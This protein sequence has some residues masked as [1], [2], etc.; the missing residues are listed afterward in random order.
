MKITAIIENTSAC[1]IPTEHGLSLYIETSEQK[2][3]FDMGQTEL[4]E[5][6]AEALGIDLSEVD[7]AVLSHGH[8]DHG[9]GLKRFLEINQKAP[10]YISRHAFGRHYN[11]TEKY[12]GLDTAL[13]NNSMLVFTDEETE[14]SKKLKLYSCN[15]KPKKYDL[16]SFGLNMLQNNAFMP[17]DFKH[18]QYLLVE[19]KG[20]NVL[21]SGCSHK[22]VLDI[23]Q[24]FKPDVFVGGFHFNS[25]PLD[26]TLAGYAKYL[27]S[28]NT[29]YYTCHCTGV[30][31]F[32]FMQKH[33]KKLKYISC[34]ETIIL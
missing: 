29:R 17:D 13:K 27:N 12:I 5:K 18:E 16:G 9:G 4:F 3:L 1:S 20:K 28:F 2:I 25:L 24:W 22:S 23:V 14:I 26:E 8:Y 33:M 32:E 30:E 31:Q 19:E 11:G 34:G 10:V 7:I 21:F 15:K 6:N